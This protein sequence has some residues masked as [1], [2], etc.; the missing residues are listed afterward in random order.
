MQYSY[1]CFYIVESVLVADFVISCT[2]D[3]SLVNL[4]KWC[5]ASTLSILKNTTYV[6]RTLEV[7]YARLS[8]LYTVQFLIRSLWS[9]LVDHADN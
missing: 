7:L 5:E 2:W 8:D 1:I 6:Y 3:Q 9:A 4:G